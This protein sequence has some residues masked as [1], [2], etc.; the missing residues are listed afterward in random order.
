MCCLCMRGK[1]RETQQNRV[2]NDGSNVARQLGC[3]LT[4]LTLFVKI[5]QG[6]LDDED[7]CTTAVL[8]CKHK[9]K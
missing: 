7:S 2:K 5:T 1:E 8:N 3:I 4:T 9:L 6:T